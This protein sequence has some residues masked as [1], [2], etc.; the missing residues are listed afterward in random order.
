MYSPISEMTVSTLEERKKEKEEEKEKE[1]ER[2][3]EKRTTPCPVG[4]TGYQRLKIIR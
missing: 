2:E 3:R 1:K 4:R